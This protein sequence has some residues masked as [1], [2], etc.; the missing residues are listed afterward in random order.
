[1]QPQAL[2]QQ[3][4]RV[5]FARFAEKEFIWKQSVYPCQL[6]SSSRWP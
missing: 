2:W 6:K 3:E 1:M 5:T 4:Y